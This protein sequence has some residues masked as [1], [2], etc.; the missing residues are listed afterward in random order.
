M[1]GV[2][3]WGQSGPAKVNIIQVRVRMDQQGLC[4]PVK[5]GL[6]EWTS[7]AH[8]ASKGWW[9]SGAQVGQ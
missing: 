5:P 7:G 4:G 9:T 2:D 3:Q 1:V 8:V 6:F